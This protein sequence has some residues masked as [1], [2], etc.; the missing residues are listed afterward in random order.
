MLAAATHWPTEGVPVAPRGWLIQTAVRRMTDQLR[1]DNAR[2]RREDVAA[3]R[4]PPAVGVPDH[5]D[6]LVL[7]LMCCHPALTPESAIA[8]TLRAIVDNSQGNRI[9]SDF[10]LHIFREA[11]DAGRPVEIAE[12]PIGGGGALVKIRTLDGNIVILKAKKPGP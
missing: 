5:D 1:S 8:L 3:Q 12:G 11:E 7:L 9:K 10:P 6:T 2:R 4:E